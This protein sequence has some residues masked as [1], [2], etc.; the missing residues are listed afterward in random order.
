MSI[1]R[2][3]YQIKVKEA[4]EQIVQ[5]NGHQKRSDHL[6]WSLVSGEIFMIPRCIN[7]NDPD[8]PK[9]LIEVAAWI[10]LWVCSKDS[11]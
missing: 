9:V 1:P 6:W 5:L 2:E 3:T 4:A 7:H 11:F 8:L 10:E